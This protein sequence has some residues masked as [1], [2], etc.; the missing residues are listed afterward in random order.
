MTITEF[1]MTLVREEGRQEG[2]KQAR[3]MNK[4]VRILNHEIALI[5]EVDGLLKQGESAEKIAVDLAQ[6]L[7][8][9]QKIVNAYEIAKIRRS[10]CEIDKEK[11]YQEFLNSDLHKVFE[12]IREFYKRPQSPNLI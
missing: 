12:S 11:R 6:P 1:R 7:K 4:Q 2:L 10:E 8:K 3:A 9:I 5:L